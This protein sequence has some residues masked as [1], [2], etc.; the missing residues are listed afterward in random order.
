MTDTPA[1]A[2]E[3]QPAPPLAEEVKALIYATAPPPLAEGEQR[4]KLLAAQAA[5]IVHLLNERGHYLPG[6]PP[7]ADILKDAQQ[8]AGQLML[9]NL[10][11]RLLR[12]LGTKIVTPETKPMERWLNDYIDGRNHG[13]LGKPMFWPQSLP[14][15][16]QQLREWGFAPTATHPPFVSR[17]RQ[18]TLQ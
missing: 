15:L 12:M 16:C 8:F 13:P 18:M 10:C 14:G 5:A 11:V 3:A 17:A 4:E 1:T 7:A 6:C 2:P 9:S